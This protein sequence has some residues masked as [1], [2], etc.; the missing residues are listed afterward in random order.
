MSIFT[1]SCTAMV[2]PF[3]ENGINFDSLGKCI[4]FQIDQGTDT[5]LACGTTGEPSN[6]LKEIRWDLISY[7]VEKVQGRILDVA[8]T[9][10]ISTVEVITA[11]LANTTVGLDALLIVHPY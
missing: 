11:S 4:E 2:T 1:G 5:L 7:T 6:I 3:T 9:C 10:G 8:I